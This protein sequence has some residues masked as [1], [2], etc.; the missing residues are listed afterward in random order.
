[1]NMQKTFLLF[2][3]SKLV[4]FQT[5][6]LILFSVT[7]FTACSTSSEDDAANKI[8]TL[9]IA[10]ANG[11][12]GSN[13][14][15]EVVATPPNASEISFDYRTDF[16]NQANPASQ[17]DLSKAT[18]GR[19]IIAA[20]DSSTTISISL[21]KDDISEQ[22]ETFRVWITNP[23]NATLSKDSAI[24]RII[25]NDSD[26]NDVV[27]ISNVTATVGDELVTLNWTNPSDSIFEG[28]IIAQAIGIT[29]P[30][31]C[32]KAANVTI[33]DAL[34][35]TSRS[36]T[37]L[38]NGTSYSFRIC[39]KY[40]NDS[41]SSGV[42]IANLIPKNDNVISSIEVDKDGDGLIEIA[43]AADL[44]NIR[45]NL[46]A[47]SYK[48]SSFDIG[49]TVGC[50]TSGCSGYELIEDIDL[51]GYTN[52]TPIGSNNSRFR[53]AT[54]DGNN[55]TIS[56]LN[57]SSGDRI[58]LFSVI[59]RVTIKNLKLTNID[60]N[61]SDFVG[62]L[63]GAAVTSTF[64]N[65]ELIGDESQASSDAEITGSGVYVG[66]L[67][68][69]FNGTIVDSSSN[70]AIRGVGN[71]S[72]I[73]GL[74]GDFKSGLITNSN[75]SGAISSVG[76]WN[77][78]GLAGLSRGNINQ[79]WASGNVLNS[80]R[81][82]GG[83][84]GYGSGNI[85]QSWASGNVSSNGDYGGGL[86]GFIIDG[87]I[88]QSWASGNV[89]SSG[90]HNW[91]YGG[92]VGDNEGG[93]I[94]NSWASGNVSSN[95]NS[96]WI[97][98]GLVGANYG[99]SISNSWAS[100]NVSSNGNKNYHY[101][102]LV[103]WNEGDISNSWA[104]G[105]VTSNGNYDQS[106]AGLVGFN[107]KGNI[108]NT[109]A[110]GNVTSN[111]SII[112]GLVSLNSVNGN[113]TGRNY[114]LDADQGVRIN[115]A[116]DDGTGDSFVLANLST[117]ANLSGAA[118]DGTS[119]WST[120]S[121]WH[122]GFDRD[123]E[124]GIDLDTMYC[125]TDNSGKIEEDEQKQ[126]N[127]VWVM[128]PIANDFPAPTDNEA[129]QPAS[130]YQIPVIGCIGNTDIERTANIDKQRRLFPRP[131]LTARIEDATG[132]EGSNL[133]FKV[134]TNQTIAE[135]I[136]FNYRIDFT[137]Q[138]NPASASDLNSPLTGTGTIS[139]NSNNTTISI[140]IADDN[141]REP[142][143]SFRIVL[144]NLSPSD[145]TFTKTEAI[146]TIAANDD[147]V[148]TNIRIEGEEGIEGSNITF[149]VTANP[150][151]VSAITFNYRTDFT[152][153]ANPA[154]ASD[155]NT[156]LTGIGTIA[157]GDSSTTISIA[158]ADDN[159]RENNETFRIVL[160]NL[161][162]SDAVFVDNVG[163]GTIAAND[164]NGSI[165]VLVANAQAGEASS[166]II[167]KVSSEFTAVSALS[168]DYEATVDN[169]TAANSASVNDFTAISGRATIPVGS[170][171]ATI[172]IPIAIDNLK[173]Q[174]ET[175]KL[176]LTNPSNAT[177]S[178]DS[179][180]GKIL[181]YNVGEV[182]N[183]AAIIGDTQITLNWTNPNDSL[184]AGVIIAQAIGIT[185]PSSCENAANVTI[186]DALKTTS[187]IITGLTNDVS[188]SFRICA[189]STIGNHSSGVVLANLTPEK[190]DDG[191]GVVGSIDVDDDNDGLIEI[192]DAAGL[193][194]IR[195]NLDATSYKTSS[196]DIGN[197]TGCPTSG[198][199]GYELIADID[200]SGYTNWMPIG[201][202]RNGFYNA[203][204]DGNNHT[205]SD[206]N[207]SSDGD[208]IGLFKEL[209][210]AT[211]KNLKLANVTVKGGSYVGALVGYALW[212]NIFN[213]ELIGDESQASS[214]AEVVGSAAKV[215]G[216]AGHAFYVMITDSSSSL[217]VRG[218]ENKEAGDIGGTGGLVGDFHGLQGTIK[219]SNSSGA[220]SGSNGAANVG[221]LVGRSSGRIHQSW[222]SG[223]VSNSNS[224]RFYGGLVGDNCGNISQS[225]ASGNV[226][227]SNFNYSYY[228]G[229]VGYNC[230]GYISQS[231]ASG[232]VSSQGNSTYGRSG[233][234]VGFMLH[235]SIAQSWASGAI[236]NRN[237]QGGLV[238]FWNSG[239]LNGRNYQ[240]DAAQG[241]G[242]NLANDD[243]IGGSFVLADFTAL[244]NLSG[245]ASDGTSDWS[246]RSG[247]HAGFDRDKEGGI[248]LDTMYCDTD[249][250]G[251]IE[252]DE[253]KPNNSVWVMPPI[254]NDFPAPTDNEAG[255][256]ASYY[257]IP[258]IGCIGNT[259]IERTA[260]ID[261]QRRLFPRPIPLTVRVED[262]TGDEGSNLIFKV[263]TNQTIAEQ[264]SFN[265]RIDFTGQANPASASDLNSSLTGTGTISANS[266]NTTISI[267]TC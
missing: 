227:S 164:E 74:V 130:Y 24:G 36:I 78:G 103:G 190:D 101:A 173:E 253:Q 132:D 178:K 123:K 221:G 112:G 46:D 257:Q 167:F 2:L 170:D 134:T 175:F 35:S 64:S 94:S 143:E 139:A 38:T 187:K 100:G 179:A 171:S 255:Q 224:G 209:E 106:Y 234:L 121:G 189:R 60:I 250:S 8:T 216:L 96:T 111:A 3:K 239:N 210:K 73:G 218:G 184:F 136:S 248:D 161:S 42:V 266:N 76:A 4:S 193:N 153:Q 258:V 115:L 201:S 215:G 133:I 47:T 6:A 229:L 267:G 89:S 152:G 23:S 11:T 249:N 169:P 157:T 129:G 265:Y 57:I 53:N 148:K 138:E 107:N 120:R 39:A 116:N 118:S 225:W 80:G 194:N 104:G 68:G 22:D 185:A 75:N 263:T 33:I 18:A 188:Y 114:Q 155:L 260:N 61:G 219:N 1:M 34:Q 137:G 262:A 97:Y 183:V 59:Q 213:I 197:A 15:F 158:V 87:S 5:L 261:R 147:V 220:V 65:I 44:Y 109:W 163:V 20:G 140:A 128:P 21:M 144:S 126:N 162:L 172:S 119:D 9:S 91:R 222:A 154:S 70:L 51:S 17:N 233:G 168:F 117:L 56:G 88:N 142:A 28:V 160:S 238:G 13:I 131:I 26:N 102:G 200:L 207:I 37:D 108:K 125:D 202:Y 71:S 159:I 237:T 228:G 217:T 240:L 31:S 45:H 231:W 259:D 203:T 32:E 156:L 14:T 67:V 198:C 50:P 72:Y 251:K 226:I 83:L 176:L 256:P 150:T 19:G 242:I 254:A 66:G 244:A 90:N 165:R 48:T 232:N 245:A 166:E 177:L 192:T 43:N 124:G 264:I 54:F 40:H 214:D 151:N 195:H 55:H 247:W 98:G 25:N 92:L 30:S 99:G 235:G 79:S 208:Y 206:L 85:N 82:S 77:V 204:F 205:I 141:L 16:T 84:V 146:G 149:S 110:S 10:D 52:W 7:L 86:V 243:G 95:G 49:S 29:A 145:A 241:R 246:T 27:E 113:I 63:A 236:F 186:I 12:E 196:F 58:G 230:G 69:Q 223:N 93:S 41:H 62:A 181:N 122:A 212:S 174:N 81:Y 211:V 180:I 182:N 127:S 135:Q 252:E 199:N 105:N 191:D